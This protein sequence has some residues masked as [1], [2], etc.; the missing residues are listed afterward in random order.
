LRSVISDATRTSPKNLPPQLR[1]G[2]IENWVQIK[3]AVFYAFPLP[4]LVNREITPVG[5]PNIVSISERAYF[6]TVLYIP[7]YYG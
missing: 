2:A 1:S 3:N 5:S 6:L 7:A 4:A